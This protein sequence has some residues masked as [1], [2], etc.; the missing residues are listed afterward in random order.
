MRKV[1]RKSA[2][3]TS[4]NTTGSWTYINGVA[5]P[6][7]QGTRTTNVEDYIDE[8]EVEDAKKVLKNIAVNIKELPNN[9]KVYFDQSVTYPRAKFRS[10]FPS[11]K[12]TYNIDKADVIIIDGTKIGSYL[13]RGFYCTQIKKVN[14]PNV[15]DAWTYSYHTDPLQHPTEKKRVY[16]KG[17]GVTLD[18]LEER[19]NTVYSME[20][21]MI[22]DVMNLNIPSEET[23]N[24]EAMD[25]IGQ[26]LA[27]QDS[28]MLNMGLRMLT[29]YNY[30]SESAKIALLLNKHWYNLRRSKKINNVETQALM[31][32]LRL[33]YTGFDCEDPMSRM[34]FWFKLALAKPDEPEIQNEVMNLT[35]STFPNLPKFKLVKIDE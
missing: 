29:A 3:F 12:I 7:T 28:S 23:L 35:R 13:T 17:Y 6:S 4:W 34:R 22:L 11:N 18:D 30:D 8:S 9:K 31:N 19:L 32:K 1:Q 15:T 33:E 26:M 24:Q 21:K 20:G 14:L 2:T 27:S 10:S 5:T 25:R 16:I